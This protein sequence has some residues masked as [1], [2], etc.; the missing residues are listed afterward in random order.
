MKIGIAFQCSDYAAYAVAA[1]DLIAVEAVLYNASVVCVGSIH[2]AYDATGVMGDVIRVVYTDKS[3]V[4]AFL[5]SAFTR[6]QSY[7]AA[8]V[9][10]VTVINAIVVTAI[11]QTVLGIACYA[12]HILFAICRSVV[13][14]VLDVALVGILGITVEPAHDATRIVFFNTY[15]IS[16][17]T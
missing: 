15:G 14:A 10:I 8:K 9:T 2:I 1:I 5:D 4:K 3:C 11:H 7:D 16:V 13:F 12:S 17:S 6:Q